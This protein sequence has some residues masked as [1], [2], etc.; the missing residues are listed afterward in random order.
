MK[1]YPP[2]D[3]AHIEYCRKNV[4][5]FDSELGFLVDSREV[6]DQ[7]NES[8]TTGDLLTAWAVIRDK[9]IDW[10]DIYKEI[11]EGLEIRV[12]YRQRVDLERKRGEF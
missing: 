1:E 12:E 10:R 9:K 5:I 3:S 6:G 4:T 11:G 7:K 8:Q 2:K